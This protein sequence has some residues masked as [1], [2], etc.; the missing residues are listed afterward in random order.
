MSMFLINGKELISFNEYLLGESIQPRE[1]DWGANPDM[2]NREVPS[3]VS[4]KAWY[5]FFQ[6]EG[7]YWAVIVNHTGE[8]GFGRSDEFSLDIM[9]YEDDRSITRSA[10]KVFNQVFY[11]LLQMLETDSRLAKLRFIKFSGT[12]PA[13]GKVYDRM[14]QNKFF[15]D[16]LEQA[17]FEYM[18]K[19]QED[20][21]FQR[22]K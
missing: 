20:H 3:V 18:G 13:L 4:G 1:T 6:A 7:A 16:Q 21:L 10:I 8:V 22:D 5:T 17:G 14:V 15:L 2:D 11:V 12:N 9:D 19:H